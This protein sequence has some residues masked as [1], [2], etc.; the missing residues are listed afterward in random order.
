MSLLLIGF[1]PLADITYPHLEQT[2][3]YFQAQGADYCLFR[4]RGYFLGEKR[5]LRK[6]FR[7]LAGL[8]LTATRI[9]IDSLRLLRMRMKHKYDVTIAVDNFSYI[10]ACW[11]FPNVVLWS[12]DFL[13]RD[14]PRSESWIQRIIFS[15]VQ[16]CLMHNHRIIIQDKER[17]GLFSE[18]YMGEPDS[19]ALE[20]FLLPVSVIGNS[21]IAPRKLGEPPVL[22]QIGGINRWRSDSDLLLENYQTHKD[23]YALA[24]HGYVDAEMAGLIANSAIAPSV[25]DVVLAPCDI[26]KIVEKCDIGFISYG[27]ANKNFYYIGRASGQIAEFTRCGKPIVILGDNNMRQILDKENFGISIVSIDDLPSA[28]LSIG[29]NYAIYS[30][31]ASRAFRTVYDLSVH[32]P[33]LKSWIFREQLN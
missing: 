18:T 3:K 10:V 25:S 27:A 6:I 23:C 2:V 31:N 30:E 11:I 15:H 22:M 20:A 29:E 7:T 5:G 24:F 1:Q 32:L 21:T 16:A 19:R 26:Y 17:L 14:E 13:T 28:V 33:R 12:H 9:A 8:F 4:E